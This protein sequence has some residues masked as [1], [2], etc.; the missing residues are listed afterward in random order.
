MIQSSFLEVQLRSTSKPSRKFC[1]QNI[2]LK[3]LIMF[4]AFLKFLGLEQFVSFL[5]QFGTEKYYF[6]P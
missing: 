6:V 2:Q 3:M 4:R 1:P 5:G